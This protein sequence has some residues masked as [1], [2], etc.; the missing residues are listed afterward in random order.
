ME[1]MSTVSLLILII[2][3]PTHPINVNN[4][5]IIFVIVLKNIQFKIKGDGS[6]NI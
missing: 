1:E 3:H 6:V 4:Y 2:F 5:L